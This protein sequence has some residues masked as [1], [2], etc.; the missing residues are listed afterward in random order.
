MLAREKEIEA[1][2]VGTQEAAEMLG[3]STTSVKKL[4]DNHQLVAWKTDGGHRRIAVESI[5]AYRDQISMTG[6]PSKGEKNF[7]IVTLVHDQ[8]P[9]AEQL[10]A[11]LD[12][13][14]L[15]FEIRSRGS[16]HGALMEM[17]VRNRN[18][19][20]ID[21]DMPLIEIIQMAKALHDLAVPNNDLHAVI[22]AKNAKELHEQLRH[23]PENLKVISGK[24]TPEW[25]QAFLTGFALA[26][27]R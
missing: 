13:C 20:L 23:L 21:A 7:C 16:L 8:K 9:W 2:F 6:R 3:L 17:S 12:N 25:L 18:L 11:Q 22:F 27:L 5:L 24:I 26:S 10:A 4:A 14:G 19:L 1:K 15:K